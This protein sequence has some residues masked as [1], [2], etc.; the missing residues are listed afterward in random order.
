MK[1]LKLC[2]ALLA[3]Y[4]S[5]PLSAFPQIQKFA[6]IGDFGTNNKCNTNQLAVSLMVNSWDP[7]Y[8]ITVGDN[9]YYG[10]NNNTQNSCTPFHV[11]EYDS[12]IKKYYGE[13]YTRNIVTNRFFPAIGD[14]EI[15]GEIDMDPRP[16]FYL[17]QYLQYFALPN[18]ERYYAFRMG[19]IQFICL[20]SDFGGKSTWTGGGL[21]PDTTVW[22][23][24][25]IDS[26]SVQ[27]LWCKSVL[28][29][30]TAKWNVVYQHKP[31]YYSFIEGY[32]DKY[33]RVRWP[34]KRWGA[35]IVLSG[36][37]H[38]YERVRKGNMTYITNGLGGGKFDPLFEDTM[39]NF[40]RIPE[41][42]LLYN[43]TLGA[44]LVEE[45]N[46]S[47][48][49][50]FVN[51]RNEVID[52]YVLLQP[53]TIKIRAF[54]EGLS[55]NS[56]NKTRPDT[57]RVY[58]R[59]PVPPFKIIDS[60]KAL[61]DSSG[62][63]LYRFNNAKYDSLYY[64]ALSH[65]NSI[66]TWTKYPVKFDDD[67]RYDFSTDSS[68]AYGDNMV[69]VGNKWCLYGGDVFRNGIVEVTDLSAVSNDAAVYQ[70]GYSRSDVNGDGIV[71][72]SDLILV[73]NN[74]FDFVSSVLPTMSTLTGIMIKP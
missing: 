73:T 39:A 34:F 60:A 62:N 5:F 56:G 14:H 17:S 48:V 3:L 19:N 41:S 65:R 45:Y 27:G 6:V 1:R 25:G 35:D 64:I 7:A 31:P 52:N 2:L 69:Q 28:D 66:E 10:R 63:G 15:A 32:L 44:Q 11:N 72:I 53:R 33:K 71:D 13:Y 49:F 57:L 38:W 58:L 47:L 46:D 30:S 59:R 43:D 36:D 55:L 18:N 22:E 50:K 68:K 51:V 70:T 4:C 67:L 20:N 24:D 26:N 12:V 8:I 29:T 16:G 9:I 40:V 23:P 21:F 42:L 37:L 74:A 61:T 54:L